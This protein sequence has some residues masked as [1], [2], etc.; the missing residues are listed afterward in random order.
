MPDDIVIQYHWTAEAL[1]EGYRWHRRRRVRP[2]FRVLLVVCWLLFAVAGARE[3]RH[4]GDALMTWLLLG[5]AIYLPVVF[6][7]GRVLAPWR[8]RR[9]FAKRPDCG[10]EVEWR[11]NENGIRI[12]TTLSKSE[13]AWKALVEVVRS[14]KGFLFYPTPQIFHWVPRYG[15]ASDAEYDRLTS[16]AQSQAAKFTQLV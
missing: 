10:A 11:I 6:V 7:L 16:L 8:I 5:F 14:P 9:R 1:Q 12:S 4:H 13:F 2:V 15:F 3:F